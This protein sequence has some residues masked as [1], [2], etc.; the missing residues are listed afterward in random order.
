MTTDSL[1]SFITLPTATIYSRRRSENTKF[2][3]LWSFVLLFCIGITSY[4]IWSSIKTAEL[5]HEV[6]QLRDKLEDLRKRMGLDLL[7]DL[8]DFEEAHENPQYHQQE[9][10]P[11][12]DNTVDDLSEEDDDDYSL[13]GFDDLDEEDGDV[14]MKE[15]SGILRM[16][17]NTGFQDDEEYDNDEIYDEIRKSRKPRSIP[18]HEGVPVIEDSYAVRRNRTNS[19][20]DDKITNHLLNRSQNPKLKYDWG[21]KRWSTVERQPPQPQNSIHRRYP[22]RYQSF[23]ASPTQFVDKDVTLTIR[24]V[25]TNQPNA[26]HI[27]HRHPHHSIHPNLQ[28]HVAAPERHVYPHQRPGNHISQNTIPTKSNEAR[29]GKGHRHARSRVIAIH[30]TGDHNK[31]NAN[32]HNHHK[33]NEKL[34]HHRG[35]YSYWSPANWASNYGMENYFVMKNGTVT[36]KEPGLY[37][38]YAQIYYDDEHDKNGFVV[39][40]NNE[41]LLLCNVMTHSERA[42]LKSNTCHTSG[43]ALLRADD[44]IEVADIGSSR[45][46][47]FRPTTSFFGLAKIGDLRSPYASAPTTV[48]PNSEDYK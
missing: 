48:I 29:T 40:H 5:R 45:Y 13:D 47:L 18:P 6:H 22:R 35:A 30:Y 46:S 15:G 3:L 8:Q 39:K 9:Y 4:T 32:L 17:P 26:L 19:P 28:E 36:V 20:I 33:I 38:I 37:L 27:R 24:E 1:K 14:E 25:D 12:F 10:P 43:V 42:V 11:D 34:K 44:Q 31:Y 16:Y 23:N 7:D 41:D 21:Q 2:I